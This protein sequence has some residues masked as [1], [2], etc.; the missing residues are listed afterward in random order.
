MA[1]F[2]V[3]NPFKEGGN[4]GK[5]KRFQKFYHPITVSGYLELRRKNFMALWCNGYNFCAASFNNR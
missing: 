2:Q 5:R 1:V 4:M 3:D